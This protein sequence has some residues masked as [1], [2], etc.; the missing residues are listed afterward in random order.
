LRAGTDPAATE[1]K[2][3][4][5][6][7]IANWPS[8]AQTCFSHETLV[9]PHTLHERPMFDDA[10]L[11]SLLDRYPR[12]RLGVFTMGD[13]P[14]AWRSWASGRPGNLSGAELLA[15]VHA[16]R[17]W[18]NLRAT[19]HYLEDYQALCDELF[20]D[21]RRNIKGLETL[22]HDLGVLI[23]SP[24]AQVF[25]HLDSALVSLWQIRGTKSVRVY[26]PKSP[27]ARPD[28]IEAVVLR[29]TP[30]QIP[31]DPTWDGAAKHV[32]LEPGMM[33]TWPQ[34]APHRIVN[35]PM[36]NVSLSVEFMTPDALVRANV[37][38]A[39]G[40][41]RRRF[42]MNPQIQKGLDPRALTKFA[43]ARA[44]KLLKLQKAH[45][46]KLPLTFDLEQAIPGV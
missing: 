31:F 16:G 18:L 4:V 42:G 32:T 2:L 36:V 46:Y 30:E 28:Q 14:V 3:N 33:V 8:D 25:Y 5:M 23:S 1:I 7:S 38:Y 44:F 11:I 19:N 17:I 34:N 45:E 41:L 26:E 43:L 22:N 21:K 6:T 24:N 39:N 37:I 12:D 20:A 29:E 27:F 15:G 13:D 9:V 10:G 35:G 40:V